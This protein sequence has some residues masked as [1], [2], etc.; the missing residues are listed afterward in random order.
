MISIIMERE[1]HHV[2]KEQSQMTVVQCH[3]DLNSKIEIA[4]VHY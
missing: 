1:E 3:N 4:I 2:L